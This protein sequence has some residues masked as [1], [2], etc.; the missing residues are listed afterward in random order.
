[1][2]YEA[3]ELPFTNLDMTYLDSKKWVSNLVKK[4]NEMPT[5]QMAGVAALEYYAEAYEPLVQI[6]RV[7]FVRK[8][9]R[10]NSHDNLEVFIFAWNDEATK[11]MFMLKYL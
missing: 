10:G 8:D 6:K 1:M 3:I 5:Q 4:A 9:K 7:Q 2:I 11:T